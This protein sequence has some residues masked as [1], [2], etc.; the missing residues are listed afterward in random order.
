MGLDGE[1][2]GM[3]GLGESAPASDLFKHFG[4]T[5]DAIVQSAEKLLG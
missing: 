4:I 3:E 2:I 5:I 1:I